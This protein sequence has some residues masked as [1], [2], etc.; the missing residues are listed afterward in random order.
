MRFSWHFKGPH[1][2]SPQPTIRKIVKLYL[3]G[4]SMAILT[5][6]HFNSYF[7]RESKYPYNYDE[8]NEDN[9]KQHWRYKWLMK[10][11]VDALDYLAQ[12]RLTN[13]VEVIDLT[14]PLLYPP[15]D[16][17]IRDDRKFPFERV[18]KIIR[19]SQVNRIDHFVFPTEL[20]HLYCKDLCEFMNNLPQSVLS[21][22]ES[23]VMPFQTPLGVLC[24]IAHIL[25]EKNAAT[26]IYAKLINPETV[27][28]TDD[29]QTYQFRPIDRV[30]VITDFYPEKDQQE[31]EK[32]G[33]VIPF[34][35]EKVGDDEFATSSNRQPATSD[36]MRCVDEIQS[37]AHLDGTSIFSL[38]A[39]NVFYPVSLKDQKVT[40]AILGDAI[41]IHHSEISGKISLDGNLKSFTVPS[42]GTVESD[43]HL[44][45]FCASIIAGNTKGIVPFVDI[46]YATVINAEAKTKPEWVIS[47]LEWIERKVPRVDI[48]VIPLGFTEFNLGLF[49]IINKLSKKMVVVCAAGISRATIRPAEI[50]Y[51]AKYGDVICVGSH[52]SSFHPSSFSPHGREIDIL[53]RECVTFDRFSV[54]TPPTPERHGE[55]AAVTP[56]PRIIHDKYSL[57]GTCIAAAYAAGVIAQIVAFALECGFER[58]QIT[59]NTVMRELLKH[60]TCNFS[61]D[62]HSGHGW[63]KDLSQLYLFKSPEYFKS[64]VKDILGNG[65]G[66]GGSST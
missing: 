5:A 11:T 29:E 44:G 16:G 38:A 63:I 22:I 25:H 64:L 56:S 27:T 15:P 20:R 18:L 53:A 34:N 13:H 21:H 10:S 7:I 42:G 57:S 62:P 32:H 59:N 4:L 50:C 33:F 6:H 36:A 3:S 43:R 61:H 8:R 65:P 9:S 23:I 49:K 14:L 45:T 54:D 28:V 24:R 52:D 1:I 51:P 46:V 17:V 55:Y 66:E 26:S 48:V 19:E 40:V 31:N 60:V 39:P 30:K 35:I 12:R 37:S 47:A 41:N 2:F 58:Q